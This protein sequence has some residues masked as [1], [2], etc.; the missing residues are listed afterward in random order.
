[1]IAFFL[2]LGAGYVAADWPSWGGGAG[3]T[4]YAPYNQIHAGNLDSLKILWRYRLP[5][6]EDGSNSEYKGTPIVVDG[7]F[8]HLD[9]EPFRHRRGRRHTA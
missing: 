1:M 6:T 5:T 3:S 2:L 7:V 9:P 4:K 8:V